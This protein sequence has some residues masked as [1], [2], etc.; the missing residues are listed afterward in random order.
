MKRLDWPFINRLVFALL[1]LFLPL[2]CTT[3]TNEATSSSVDAVM[4]KP[5]EEGKEVTSG[6]Q[7]DSE[8]P[9]PSIFQRVISQINKGD[10]LITPSDYSLLGLKIAD[11]NPD[12]EI[13]S[14]MELTKINSTDYLL[15]T[16]QSENGGCNDITCFRK[17][18][19]VLFNSEKIISALDYSIAYQTWR[20]SKLLHNSFLLVETEETEY[21]ENENGIMVPS[22]DAKVNRMYTAVMN[23]R[24]SSLESFTKEELKLCR[25]TVFARYGYQF[26][27]EKLDSY[28]SQLDWYQ[29]TRANVDGQLTDDDKNFI[30]YIQSLEA[31]R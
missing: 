11:G 10:A 14:L 26:K 30:Q 16:Y 23:G 13:R 3:K 15:A 6:I 9:A 7:N 18:N 20:S 17:I 25:N 8:A 5:G 2:A 31:L 1:I 4:E 28:F 27:D 24:V 12:G 22:E 19:L 21:E 29:P